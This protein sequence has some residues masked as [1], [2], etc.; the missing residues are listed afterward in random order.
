MTPPNIWSDNPDPECFC[1]SPMNVCPSHG[2]RT[3]EVVP[4]EYGDE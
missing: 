2:E 1:G 4:N 3:P